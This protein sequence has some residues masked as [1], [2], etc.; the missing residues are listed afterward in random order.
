MTFVGWL[1]I[2]IFFGLILV[3]TKPI[4][5][6]M[7]RVFESGEAPLGRF[8][9]R[10]EN[11]FYRLCGIDPGREQDWKEYAFSLLAFSAFGVLVTFAIMRLQGHLPLNPQHFAGVPQELAFNTA[12]SFTTNTNWQSYSGEAT[13][14]YFSQMVALTIHNFTSAAAGIA[15]AA[16]LVRGIARQ[17]AQTI[18]NFWTDVVRITYYVLV[19]LCLVFAM[20][21]VSQGMIQNFKPYTVARTYEP[22]T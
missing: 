20:F 18:G 19:P 7:F 8:L 22:Y 3:V 14:S 21:L 15:I 12:A 4:G 16:A 11:L 1:Q 9:G 2:A 17:T 10:I 5:A 6:Y 13:M